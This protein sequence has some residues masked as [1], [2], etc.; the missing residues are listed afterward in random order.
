MI[1]TVKTLIFPKGSTSTFSSTTVRTGENRMKG[2]QRR[3]TKGRLR[4]IEVIGLNIILIN[5]S[6]YPPTYN[7]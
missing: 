7:G 4:M 2:R 5:I 3:G 6:I 1:L